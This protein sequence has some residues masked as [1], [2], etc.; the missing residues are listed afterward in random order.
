MIIL[1]AVEQWANAYTFSTTNTESNNNK[2]TYSNF[3]AMVCPADKVDGLIFDGQ[4]YL[5]YILHCA[6][7]LY[8]THSYVLLNLL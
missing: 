3:I 2:E 5:L 4:V 7:D 1:P 6:R 8:S